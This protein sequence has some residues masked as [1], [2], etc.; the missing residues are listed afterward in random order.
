[1]VDNPILRLVENAEDIDEVLPVPPQWSDVALA[2]RFADA[3]SNYTRYVHAWG[4]WLFWDGSCWQTDTTLRVFKLATGIVRL[5]AAEVPR[6][7]AGAAKQIASSKTV[8]ATVTLARSDARIAATIDQWDSDPWLLNTPAGVIDLRTGATRQSRADDY[9]TM[10]T[11]AS[12]TLNQPD[13]VR[14]PMWVTFLKRIFDQDEDLIRYVQRACGY[15]LTGSTIEQA[16]FFLYGLGQN[17]KSK[18]VETVAGALGSYATTAPI[19]TFMLS[20]NERHPTELAMLRGVRLVTS[21]ETEEGRTWAES[22]IKMLTG[23][24]QIAARYMRQDFFTFTPKFKLVIFGNHKPSLR[25][26]DKAMKRRMNLWPFLV[27]IPDTEKDGDLGHKLKT[28]WAGILG[29]M[30]EG[31]LA[32]QAYKLTPPAAVVSA[33]T[34]YLD[35]EDM[36]KVWFEECCERCDAKETTPTAWLFHSWKLWSERAEEYTGTQRRFSQK[37]EML[38]FR[39]FLLNDRKRDIRNK[40]G[41]SGVRLTRPSARQATPEDSSD[42]QSLL[43]NDPF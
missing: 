30:V 20:H 32:W 19:E 14:C 41:Y 21:V 15:V 23:G 10:Q 1:M 26:V 28:E 38:G 40:M 27:Q 7:R 6:E 36:F 13:S 12:P 24:D 16:L 31:C 33:T 42:Q 3:H 11:A 4:K 39:S 2:Q 35:Q 9:A 43:K 22:R 8:A 17:G 37:L 25:T 34:D 29:W 5:A 18:F